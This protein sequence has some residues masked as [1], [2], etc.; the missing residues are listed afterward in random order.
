M[1]PARVMV[2]IE[3]GQFREAVLI[4]AWPLRTTS[5]V[6]GYRAYQVLL[7]APPPFVGRPHT[8]A[9]RARF[10]LKKKSR[11]RGIIRHFTLAMPGQFGP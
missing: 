7:R 11:E 3:N 4:L 8:W 9:R 10:I 6:P 2:C 1:V 5:T